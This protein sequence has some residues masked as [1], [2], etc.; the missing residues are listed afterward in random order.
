MEEKVYFF[1][2]N[3]LKRHVAY[4]HQ[5]V[6]SVKAHTGTPHGYPFSLVSAKPARR[7]RQMPPLLY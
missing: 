1:P 2:V 4:V 3:Y 7:N 5:G 6:F